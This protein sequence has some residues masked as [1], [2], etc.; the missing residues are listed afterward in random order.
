MSRESSGLDGTSRLNKEEKTAGP[1]AGGL[2]LKCGREKKK[3]P[4]G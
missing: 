1:V 3:S 2:G 4:P